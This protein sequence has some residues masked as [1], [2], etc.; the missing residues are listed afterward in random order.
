TEN[1]VGAQNPHIA[2]TT[3]RDRLGRWNVILLGE[4][5]GI[6]QQ[7]FQFVSIKASEVEIET[8]AF[9]SLQ[10]LTQQFVIPASIERQAIV[11][12]DVS[13][14]L[15]IGEMAQYDDWHL[16]QLELARRQ[17]PRM[18]GDDAILCVHQD[19]IRKPKFGN[20]VR[21]LP[22]LVVGVGTSIPL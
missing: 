7:T 3:N 4:R 10:L 9:E 21:N 6:L 20:A 1:P 22:D 14:F 12:Q 16:L 11:G 19:W 17:Q 13:A 15:C 2:G 5:R 8:F 18:A